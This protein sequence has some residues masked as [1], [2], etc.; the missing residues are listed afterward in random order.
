[1]I[2]LKVHNIMD[3]VG[4]AFLILAPFLF[5]FSAVD[6][7]RNVFMVGGFLLIMYSLFTNYYYAAIRVIP[8][9]VHMA[10]DAVLAVVLIVAPWVFQ[11]RGVVT[12]GQETLHYVVGVG[13]LGLVALTA[14]RTETE[15][16]E[17]HI[18]VGE[19]ALGIR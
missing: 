18:H 7:A 16:R 8:L 3:Y 2:P 9:G 17:H 1:M 14:E 5:G 6:T 15:K 10:F 13:L 11:Y 4:G 19:P 12:P